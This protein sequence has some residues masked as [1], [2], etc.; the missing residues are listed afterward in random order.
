MNVLVQ[1][2]HIDTKYLGFRSIIPSYCTIAEKDVYLS[3]LHSGLPNQKL[4]TVAPFRTDPK[5]IPIW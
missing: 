3:Y 1:I 4:L 5:E 2:L